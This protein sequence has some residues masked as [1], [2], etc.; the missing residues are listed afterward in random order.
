MTRELQLRLATRPRHGA[1]ARSLNDV[2]NHNADHPILCKLYSG[3]SPTHTRTFYVNDKYRIAHFQFV[4][5]DT[6]VPHNIDTKIPE[7]RACPLC[8]T[9]RHPGTAR[10]LHCLCPNPILSNIRNQ[11]NTNI[12]TTLAKFDLLRQQAPNPPTVNIITAIGTALHNR[13]TTDRQDTQR[14]RTIITTTEQLQAEIRRRETRLDPLPNHHPYKYTL[15]HLPLLLQ[16]GLLPITEHDIDGHHEI[17]TDYLYQGLLPS[18]LPSTMAHARKIF[19]RQAKGANHTSESLDEHYHQLCDEN[20]ALAALFPLQTTKDDDGEPIERR[21]GLG[22]AL[23][24]IQ[25]ELLYG[26]NERAIRMY[27]IATA[28]IAQ[29]QHQISSSPTDTMHQPA[30]DDDDGSIYSAAS[31]NSRD[32]DDD[33]ISIDS[34]TDQPLATPTKEKSNLE[35]PQKSTC[36]LRYPEPGEKPNHKTRSTTVKEFN[37]TG[38][39]CRLK[40]TTTP[41]E[42]GKVLKITDTCAQCQQ[43]QRA[44]DLCTRLELAIPNHRDHQLQLATQDYWRKKDLATIILHFPTTKAI[45]EEWDKS[46]KITTSEEKLGRRHILDACQMLSHSFLRR[47]THEFRQYDPRSQPDQVAKLLAAPHQDLCT[48][49]PPQIERDRK[50]GIPLHHKPPETKP[51]PHICKTCQGMQI[52]HLYAT[53]ARL[54]PPGIACK[55]CGADPPKH[56]GV[57]YSP[58]RALLG[59]PTTG[60]RGTP[61]QNQVSLSTEKFAS[62]AIVA[63]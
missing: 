52:N 57:G 49:P 20:A 46:H 9:T 6:P 13:D 33:A 35:I 15:A 28:K 1:F 51:R 38:F 61:R 56:L 25:T 44:L 23:H 54:D 5:P 21:I 12:N 41:N 29:Y 36:W 2:C 18:S 14:H 16:A 43:H 30:N 32:S 60:P 55:F 37:C 24:T 31:Y 39:V 11:C 4:N 22:A 17:P 40:R 47:D 58:Y 50:T 10:H 53:K 62:V 8:D 34:H 63:R 48:C 42:I 3:Q 26:L 7:L 45:V 59:L 27:Q 19:R